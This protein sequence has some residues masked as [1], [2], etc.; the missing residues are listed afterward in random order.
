V[1]KLHGKMNALMREL[2]TLNDRMENIQA[3]LMSISTGPLAT[4]RQGGPTE[5]DPPETEEEREIF[6]YVQALVSPA[7][8]LSQLLASS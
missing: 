3:H 5:D 6:A 7:Q 1:G 2:T 4:C 8:R